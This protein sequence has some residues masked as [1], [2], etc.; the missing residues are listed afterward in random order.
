M[1]AP[2]KLR[3]KLRLKLATL[4]AIEV[5][6]L[7]ILGYLTI[8]KDMDSLRA[9]KNRLAGLDYLKG[10]RDLT[11]HLQRHR[12]I[13]L[14]L[15]GGDKSFEPQLPIVQ[16]QLTDDLEVLR[17]ID[18]EH[19]PLLL[20]S[21]PLADIQDG[22]EAL[23]ATHMV[24]K[25]EDSNQLHNRLVGRVLDLVGQVSNSS[26][27]V[28]VED[29]ER[30]FLYDT[31]AFRL[32][33]QIDVL[34]QAQTLATSAAVQKTMTP[35]QRMELFAT[36]R[37]IQLLR[38]NVDR[39]ALQLVNVSPDLGG[40]LE[41]LV[42]ANRIGCDDLNLY[43]ND[44]LLQRD[45]VDVDPA[46][47]FVTAQRPIDTALRLYD[48]QW[49]AVKEL[50]EHQAAAASKRLFAAVGIMLGGLSLNALLLLLVSRGIIRQ[51]QALAQT[52]SEVEDGNYQARA[53]V[54]TTDEIGQ[55]AQSLNRMLDNT[56]VLIQSRDERDRIQAA[57]GQLL[58]EVHGAAAGDLR[59][60]AAGGGEFTGPIAESFN[61]MMRQLRQIIGRVQGASLNVS[62]NA[63][64]VR[65]MTDEL[66][67]GSRTQ[68]EAIDQATLAVANL[69][70]A[71]D[72]IAKNMA[73]SSE[74][75]HQALA[76][77]QKGLGAVQKITQ[78]M[79][80]MRL[81]VDTTVGTL[82]QL[83][84][85]ADEVTAMGR[86]IDDVAEWSSVLAL[87][88][89]LQ[90]SLGGAQ[91]Q[92]YGAI[93]E[94][95]DRLA[96]RAAEAARKLDGLRHIQAST[97]QAVKALESTGRHV[98]DSSLI[99]NQAEQALAE[100]Q[101]VGQRLASLLQATAGIAREQSA[102]TTTLSGTMIDV[103]DFTQ[104][105]ARGMRD[106]NGSVGKLT[107]LAEELRESVSA[108]KL[109]HSQADQLAGGPGVSFLSTSVNGDHSELEEMLS[110]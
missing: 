9:E 5:I 88:A 24:G 21:E 50:T 49:E 91:G 78:G 36:R 42:V 68:A 14:A 47:V 32:L 110:H 64:E 72:K 19:G 108:F 70:T 103:A 43:M 56:L 95:A 25:A 58:D 16:D 104:K 46:S 13:S 29:E 28:R 80:S 96:G 92:R 62:I 17:E 81:Q 105:I 90:A 89:S 98:V 1:T 41:G 37:T 79:N 76:A 51:V 53:P 63:G 94:T 30:Y 4:I 82:S 23:R 60:E 74:V 20:T 52:F 57:V 67:H 87:N 33:P 3:T 84:T 102:S 106:T 35:A 93:A 6:S 77:A 7:S 10:L 2:Y 71:V 101:Q 22:W 83:G 12:T 31:L 86:L 45:R 8:A 99:A 27:M 39:N 38:D 11:E 48:A 65:A 107:K 66:S 61:F 40:E 54:L 97:S 44:T 100:I 75:A 73:T 15:L 109:P 55:A 69:S 59:R 18:A 26:G 34:A 85:S